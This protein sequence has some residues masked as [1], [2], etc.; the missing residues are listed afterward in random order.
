[1]T[2][3][4]DELG[5]VQTIGGHLHASHGDHALVHSNELLLGDLDI[6]GGSIAVVGL[7]GSLVEVDADV[8]GGRRSKGADGLFERQK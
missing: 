2:E 4:A 6:E 3:T 5:L 8:A 7:E 1:V